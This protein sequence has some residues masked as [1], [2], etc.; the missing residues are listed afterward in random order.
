MH[1]SR[2]PSGSRG[3]PQEPGPHRGAHAVPRHC[4]ARPSPHRARDSCRCS[5]Q[6]D[7]LGQAMAAEQ[8][9][10]LP[11]QLE[12]LGLL[13]VSPAAYT[14]ATSLPQRRNLILDVRKACLSR[15]F[16]KGGSCRDAPNGRLLSITS[17]GGGGCDHPS[18]LRLLTVLRL[19]I[20]VGESRHASL[21]LG[22]RSRRQLERL[23]G[24]PPPP[25]RHPVSRLKKGSRSGRIS[26]G[27][28]FRDPIFG[29]RTN[30]QPG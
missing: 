29:T 25:N 27:G 20:R 24:C 22:R 18:Q 1:S 8:A 11:L 30:R 26:E 21:H 4:P 3:V 16:G 10:A 19:F 14:G 2:A 12:V 5:L 6:Q 15:A 17:W 28:R 7:N 23:S 9:G 13:R